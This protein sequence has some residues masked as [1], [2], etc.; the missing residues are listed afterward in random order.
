MLF[1]FVI[2]IKKPYCTLVMNLQVLDVASAETLKSA[3]PN[4][5]Q[6]QPSHAVNAGSNVFRK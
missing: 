6:L 2:Y 3:Y 1:Y 4:S 5:T